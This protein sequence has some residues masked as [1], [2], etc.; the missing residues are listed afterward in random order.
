MN[1][2][3]SAPYWKRSFEILVHVGMITS[4]NL[5]FFMDITCHKDTKM[6]S[7]L[8]IGK[9]AELIVMFM[10][11]QCVIMLKAADK[12]WANCG[13]EEM[14]MDYTVTILKQA[15][16]FKWWFTGINRSTV[17][18]ENIPATITPPAPAWILDTRQVVFME[19]SNLCA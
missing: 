5:W 16:A 6:D 8:A 14:H 13:Y 18:R 10:T 7:D 9:N 11:C 15:E 4:H 12:R 17:C 1:G 19:F 2:Q 3:D